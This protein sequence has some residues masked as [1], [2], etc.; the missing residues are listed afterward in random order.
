MS[1]HAETLQK[2]DHAL[3]ANFPFY[4]LGTVELAPGIDH[5]LT[6]ARTDELLREVERSRGAAFSLRGDVNGLLVV[7]FDQALDVST[8]TELGNVIASQVV[9]RLYE[10][11]SLDVVLSPPRVVDGAQVRDWV[12]PHR[13]L[14]IA[15]TYHHVHEQRKLRV[16]TL[17]LPATPL[18]AREG[19]RA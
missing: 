11:G 3:P 18:S 5:D 2:I 19:A 7:L 16:R 13:S 12:D 4:H 9:N 14:C 6:P 17:I 10:L 15:R 8:Y 1:A